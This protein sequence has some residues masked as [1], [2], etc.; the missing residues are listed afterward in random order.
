MNE[1]Y[2]LLHANVCLRA[3][4]ACHLTYKDILEA[5]RRTTTTEPFRQRTMAR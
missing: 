5:W 4:T 3:Y 2:S 1:E